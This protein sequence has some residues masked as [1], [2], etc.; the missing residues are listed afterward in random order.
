MYHYQKN[1]QLNIVFHCFTGTAKLRNFCLD[2]EFFISLS[3]IITFKNAHKLR[4]VIQC[5]P[6]KSIL[7]ETDSPFLAP[8]PFRGKRNE[9]SYVKYVGEYLSNFYNTS[10]EEISSVTDKNFYKLFSKAIQYNEIS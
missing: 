1:K 5:V 2:N 4:E 6:L 7:I 9:P 10:F 8:M 3:G